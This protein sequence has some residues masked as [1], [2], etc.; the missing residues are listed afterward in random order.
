MRLSAFSRLRFTRSLSLWNNP[1]AHQKHKTEL[2]G[3]LGSVDPTINTT[4]TEADKVEDEIQSLAQGHGLV[5][6]NPK[7]RD[8]V[9]F[10]ADAA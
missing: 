9:I 1:E 4:Q 2:L 7:R 3:R 10:V 6:R 8:C 5:L